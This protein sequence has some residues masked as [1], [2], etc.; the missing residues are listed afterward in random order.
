[1]QHQLFHRFVDT[2]SRRGASQHFTRQQ[3]TA[4]IAKRVSAATATI[5]QSNKQTVLIYT[6]PSAT[7]SL[8]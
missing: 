1:M 2:L 7:S 4:S 8:V 3:T 5:A 6:Q